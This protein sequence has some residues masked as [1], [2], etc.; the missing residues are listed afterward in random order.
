MWRY[1][2]RG[3][4]TPQCGTR[5]LHLNSVP[6]LAVGSSRPLYLEVWPE[7]AGIHRYIHIRTVVEQQ[8]PS[9]IQNGMLLV[10]DATQMLDIYL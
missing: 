7:T 9:T 10:T 8:V 5:I 1:V 2:A 3:S 4:L 6:D